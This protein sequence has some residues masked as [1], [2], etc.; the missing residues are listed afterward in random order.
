MCY[1]AAPANVSSEKALGKY[2]K[3]AEVEYQS[4]SG[5]WVDAVVLKDTGKGKLRLDVKQG[6][7]REKVRLRGGG[8]GGGGGAPSAAQ[9]AQE[10]Q[11]AAEREAREARGREGEAEQAKYNED[12]RRAR[13]TFVGPAAAQLRGGGVV[14]A[15]SASGAGE[16]GGKGKKKGAPQLRGQGVTKGP[17]RAAMYAK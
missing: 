1:T 11:A 8:G 10:Q 2:E 5:A 7:R 3:G 16:K 4:S 15:R 6:A 12:A 13:A 17:K 9:L 14:E